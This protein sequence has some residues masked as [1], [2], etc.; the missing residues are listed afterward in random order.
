[1]NNYERGFASWSDPL[2]LQY[3]TKQWAEQKESTKNFN[4]FFQNELK[5]STRVIDL[6]AGAGAATYFLS[7]NHPKTHFIGVDQSEKL[8]DIANG[9]QIAKEAA[10]LRFEVGNWFDLRHPQDSIDGVVS[11]QTLSWLPELEA[12]MSQIFLKIKPKWIGLSS[13]FYDGGITCKIE[14]HEHIRERKTFYNVYSLKE[15]NRFANSFGYEVTRSK[16]FNLE[17]DLP[18]PKNLDLMG[19]Y[20]ERVQRK[21]GFERLQISG[22]LLLNWKFVLISRIKNDV[23]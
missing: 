11:L 10:N 4:K 8:I 18:K 6:G 1:M 3:H 21:I 17:I 19:T 20:T 16:K 2:S 13:L 23:K 7:Q 9:M 14:V 22:P 15:L 12:P 5:N